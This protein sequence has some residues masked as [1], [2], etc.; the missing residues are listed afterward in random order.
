MLDFGI[1]ASAN[2]VSTLTILIMNNFLPLKRSNVR[3]SK[4]YETKE[5]IIKNCNE[6]I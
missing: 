6:D 1:E 2:Y 3:R 5:K 4:A